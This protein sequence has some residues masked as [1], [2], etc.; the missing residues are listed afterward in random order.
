MNPRAVQDAEIAAW[1][2]LDW[3]DEEH[4]LCLQVSGASSRESSILKQTP[5]A[6][7]AWVA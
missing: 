6:L 5:Q 7:H 2:G 4:A 3:A 1:V